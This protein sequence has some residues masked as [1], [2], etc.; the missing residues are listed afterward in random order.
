MDTDEHD[1]LELW[2]KLG[3][4]PWGEH[5]EEKKLKTVV[6]RVVGEGIALE[7][8]ANAL[9]DSAYLGGPGSG[10]IDC[11]RV[12]GRLLV[13]ALFDHHAEE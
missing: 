3:L 8:L 1:A 9:R 5:K 11:E 7:V 6:S 2:N 4:S 13:D 10:T 12:L